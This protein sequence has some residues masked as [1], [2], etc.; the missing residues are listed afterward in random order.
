MTPSNPVSGDK[1]A[2][3]SI[4][5]FA[6]NESTTIEAMLADLLRQDLL[7]ET[8]PS[9]LHVEIICIANGCTDDTESVA[10]NTLTLALADHPNREQI[11]WRVDSLPTPGKANA[12]NYFVHDASHPDAVYLVCL[13]ADIRMPQRSCLKGVL[14]TLRE[15]P[16]AN[17]AVDRPVK[18]IMLRAGGGPLTRLNRA[19]TTA[20]ANA[21]TNGPNQIAGSLFCGRADSLRKIW[22]P[23]RLVRVM[24]G[25]IKAMLITNRFTTP[26]EQHQLICST[27]HYHVFEAYNSIDS[28][29]R[30]NR[31]WLVGNISNAML[32]GYLWEHATPEC[33]A[34]TLIARRNSTDPNWLRWVINERL[35]S[36]TRRQLLIEYIMAPLR[37]CAGARSLATIA[38]SIAQ[39]MLRVPVAI[40]ANRH[41]LAGRQEW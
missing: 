4:G 20:K 12:W 15:S 21:R 26:E 30:H 2:G 16:H 14:N 6:H 22:L 35:T 10:K 19:V 41:L 39:A 38:I 27:A 7:T 40:S 33:D 32:Y 24:D 13:D 11:T 34:G 37:E 29:F 3:I 23:T 5:V 25:F 36:S 28:L 8:I 18:D 1:C 17:I 9:S 31:N